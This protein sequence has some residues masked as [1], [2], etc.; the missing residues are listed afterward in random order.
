[1]RKITDEGTVG[2]LRV[3]LLALVGLCVVGTAASLAY[4]RHW[5]EPW[6]LVPWATLGGI[7]LASVVLL[8]RVTRI[9]VCFTR[10]V[11]VLTIVSA[12]LGLWQHFDENYKTAPLDGDFTQRWGTMS[13]VERWWAVAGGSVGH[14]PVLAAGALV[15]T[16]LALWMV[17]TGFGVSWQ[18]TT[19]SDRRLT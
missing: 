6:Q 4:D 3:A 1:M 8:L 11:A 13:T 19:R 15:P 17:T 18:L 2:R 9:T 10:V 5:D 7:V 16:G 14:V 12:L